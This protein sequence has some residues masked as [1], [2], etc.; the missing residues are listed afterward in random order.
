MRRSGSLVLFEWTTF[1]AGLPRKVISSVGALGLLL[2][3]TFMFCFSD[4]RRRHGIPD[5][6]TRPFDVA[7]K[8]VARKKAQEEV[9]RIQLESKRPT[10]RDTPQ[11]LNS[12]HNKE[13]I[14]PNSAQVTPR[15]SKRK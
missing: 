6:D 9:E 3:H 13:N 8:D 1:F 5:S 12:S 2:L 7:Y 11:P 4:M 10:P 15:P 14:M